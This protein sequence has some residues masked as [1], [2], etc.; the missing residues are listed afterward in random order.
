MIGYYDNP[1]DHDGEKRAKIYEGVE[2]EVNKMTLRDVVWEIQ[3]LNSNSKLYAEIWDLCQEE[4]RKDGAGQ[5]VEEILNDLLPKNLELFVFNLNLE[6]LVRKL[7]I[8]S[9]FDRAMEDY[10]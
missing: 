9:M 10:D 6:A 7:L 4:W 5:I 8:E 2:K 1:V 3:E